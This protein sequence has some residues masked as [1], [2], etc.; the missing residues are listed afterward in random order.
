MPISLIPTGNVFSYL[1]AIGAGAVVITT[2]PLKVRASSVAGLKQIPRTTSITWLAFTAS[3]DQATAVT[4]TPHLVFRVRDGIKIVR[5]VP[6]IIAAVQARAQELKIML[7][8]GEVAIERASKL[9]ARID[10]VFE[11]LRQSGELSDFNTGFKRYR[12][13]QAAIGRRVQ[14]YCFWYEQLRR[15]IIRALV[16]KQASPALL[17]EQIRKDFF[18]L[19]GATTGS[20]SITNRAI[21]EEV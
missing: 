1:C 17:M 4:H 12:L 21:L 5:T 16:T 9:A 15:T 10:Q 6:E 2:S 7:T 14:P 3:L 18:W 11:Q 8:P 13:A 20:L 19:G